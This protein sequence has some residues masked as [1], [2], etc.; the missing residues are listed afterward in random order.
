MLERLVELKD[1]YV[2]M[3]S[4][5]PNKCKMNESDWHNLEGILKILHLFESL[6]LKLQAVNFT[7]SD[8]YAAWQELKLEMES[9]AGAD[10]VDKWM[11][12]SPI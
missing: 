5:M 4:F 6:T 10:L 3:I 11:F 8:F 2:S 12:E 7:V 9:L 1:F